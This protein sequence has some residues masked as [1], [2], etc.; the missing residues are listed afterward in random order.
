[1]SSLII[2]SVLSYFLFHIKN[3]GIKKSIPSLLFVSL[4]VFATN[5][6][7]YGLEIDVFRLLHRVI[8]IFA[9]VGL[10]AYLI[11]HKI[12]FIKD[13]VAQFFLLFFLILLLSFIGNDIY[14]AHYYH[15]LRNFVFI[16]SIV[17]YLYY[18]IDSIGKL[19]EIYK[20]ILGITFIL[21][22]FM[23]IETLLINFSGP[24]IDQIIKDLRLVRVSLFYSN[25]NYLAYVLFLGLVISLFSKERYFSYISFTILFAIFATAS[26]SMILVSFVIIIYSLLY[27]KYRPRYIVS[28]LVAIFLVLNVIS[29]KIFI[30][31]HTSTFRLAVP[32]ITLNIFK[33][34]FLNGMGYGQFRVN[35]HKYIDQE[36]IDMNSREINESFFALNPN[37]NLTWEL[38]DKKSNSDKEYLVNDANNKE[39]M[40][41]NDLF[42]IISELGLIG[43]SFII[44]LFYRLYL[45]L[46]RIKVHDR[47]HYFVSLSLITGTLMFSLFHNNMTT[48]IFWFVLMVPFIYN[49]NVKIKNTA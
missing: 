22:V 13:S 37:S 4:Y 34:H 27:K 26:R 23:V 18:Q 45:E 11:R 39:K 29:E 9:I 1:M 25:S 32:Q 40:T 7:H 12:N 10:I 15:Y 16:A 38:W 33:E 43:I 44:F 46:K 49:R 6:T 17:L 24:N 8:G 19:E 5:Y 35:F 21:S 14:M 2:I 30:N 31:T 42:T 20:L 3:I 36:I 48:F 41:H 47:R 28:G